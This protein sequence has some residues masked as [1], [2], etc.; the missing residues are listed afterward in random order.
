MTECMERHP[1]IGVLG[2]KLL[3]ARMRWS[4]DMGYRAP[5]LRTVINEYFSLSRLIPL[6]SIFP[7]IVRSRDVRGLEDCDWV[8]GASLMARREVLERDLWDEAIFFFA[9]E[10]EFCDRVRERG[11][12]VCT[13]ADARVVHYS[14][15]SMSKQSEDFLKGKVSGLAVYLRRRRGPLAAALALKAVR[16]SFLARSLGH[17]A[18]YLLSGN[19]SSAQK[20][21]RLR[22]YLELD[23]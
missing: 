9:E 4:R 15:M 19:P 12:R 7:G 18:V 23:S 22:Q 8:S 17:R 1:D 11:W 2:S 6:P 3:D 16:F 14:G 13:L 20:S 10:I 5:T 21:R